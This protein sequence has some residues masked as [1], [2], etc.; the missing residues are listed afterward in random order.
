MA[1]AIRYRPGIHGI[2]PSGAVIAAGV[3]ALMGFYG[4]ATAVQKAAV[5]R[6]DVVAF[7]AVADTSRPAAPLG[8]VPSL[9]YAMADPQDTLTPPPSPVSRRAIAADSADTPPDVRLISAP[10]PELPLVIVAT[11]TDSSTPNAIGGATDASTIVD[12]AVRP[13]ATPPS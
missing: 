13:Q 4:F 12:P 1:V 11:D 2:A 10:A 3:I 7:T 5:R 9:V 8:Q 6:D